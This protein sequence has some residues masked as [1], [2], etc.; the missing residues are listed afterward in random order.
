MDIW[1]IRHGETEWNANGLLQGWTDIPLNNVGRLQA[2]Q[3]ATSLEGIP[4][5]HI[6][7]SDLSRA[8]QTARCIARKTG[9]PIT[10]TEKL[11]EQFFGQAEGLTREESDLRFPNRA[12]D[13]ETPEHLERRVSAFIQEVVKRHHSGR[14]ILATHGRVIRAVLEWLGVGVGVGR[15]PIHN[16]S[17]T[18]IRVVDGHYRVLAINATGHLVSIPTPLNI[19][20][21]S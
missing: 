6:Y 11:R 17:I 15:S 20:G 2:Q 4:F 13:Q 16:T 19:K 14:I 9:A 10:I 1:L 18:R 12:P 7:T 5:Q 3:L 21:V 8:A